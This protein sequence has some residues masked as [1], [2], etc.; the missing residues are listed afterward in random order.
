MPTASSKDKW[1]AFLASRCPPSCRG[2]FP[3]IPSQMLTGS[4][5][6]A[7]S[8][9]NFA[10]DS[11][12][13]ASLHLPAFVLQ[14]VEPYYDAVPVEGD[15]VVS[16]VHGADG[17]VSP[18]PSRDRHIDIEHREDHHLATEV[19]PH[20]RCLQDAELLSR[21]RPSRQVERPAA[22]RQRSR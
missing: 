19:P 12:A 11:S 15:L 10:S 4:E 2:R 6:P 18:A 13:V 14:V 3:P 9:K 21:P 20:V 17:G 16:A 8:W 5:K 1:E 7:Q 22:A